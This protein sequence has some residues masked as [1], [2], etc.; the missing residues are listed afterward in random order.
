MSVWP[1][2]PPAA[3]E[4]VKVLANINKKRRDICLR[5]RPTEIFEEVEGGGGGVCLSSVELVRHFFTFF[6]CWKARPFFG[7]GIELL[8]LSDVELSH[9]ITEWRKKHMGI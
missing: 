2:G 1:I 5:H 4:R 8:Y 3:G 6:R 7:V 9:S